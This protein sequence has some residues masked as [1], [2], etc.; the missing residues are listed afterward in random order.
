MGFSGRDTQPTEITTYRL[1]WPKGQFIEK[2]NT[3]C[4]YLSTLVS[5]IAFVV[6]VNVHWPLS[7]FH[8]KDE[9]AR[10]KETQSWK[11]PPKMSE[12]PPEMSNQGG[13]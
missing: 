4:F 11:N 9:A 5:F 7:N 13:I 3:H 1:N 2:N 10:P 6:T 8:L 12:N